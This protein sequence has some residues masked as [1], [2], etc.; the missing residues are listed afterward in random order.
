M[1]FTEI[2]TDSKWHDLKTANGVRVKVRPLTG[3]EY[4][5]VT[6]K[7]FAG[8]KDK[9]LVYCVITRN[10]LGAAIEGISG[11]EVQDRDKRP[12]PAPKDG[13]ELYDLLAKGKALHSII[14][15]EIVSI[16]M[17]LSDVPGEDLGN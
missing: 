8:R 7:S 3:A 13:Y 6:R 1:I 9:D 11:V 4:S 2:C 10:T 14:I 17:S 12:M 15:D 16:I 5:A